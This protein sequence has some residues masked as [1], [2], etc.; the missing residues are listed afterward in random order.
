MKVDFRGKWAKGVNL[1]R[2]REALTASAL[3]GRDGVGAYLG[4][5]GLTLVQVRQGLSGVQVGH[6]ETYPVTSG[7]M[8]ELAPALKETVAAW[9]LASGP[10]S[11]AVSPHLGFCRP[12]SL[13]RAASENLAQVVAYELDRFVPVPADRLFYGFQVVEETA[14]EIRLL[15]MAVAR[16]RVEEC[17][18]L[19]TEAGLRPVA[20]ELAPVA[21]SQVFTLSGRSLPAWL[22]LHLEEDA[23]ELTLLKGGQVQAF[24]QGRHLQGRDLSR[25]VLAQVEAMAAAGMDP[26]VLGIYGRGGAAFP[27]GVLKKYE[28]ETIYA[29]QLPLPGLLPEMNLSEVLPAVGAG[30]ACFGPAAG[31]VNL[32]PPASRAAIRLG[33][34]SFTTMVLLVFLGLTCLWGASAFLHTRVELYRVNRQIAGLS[35]E[36][37]E[38]EKLLKES[39][40][41]AQQLESLGKIAESPDKLT[42]LK[43]LTRLIPANTWLVNLRL[44][45]Q[46]LD[47]SGMSTAASDLIPR[48]D[49]SGLL[50]KTEFASPIVTDADKLEHFKIKA[51]F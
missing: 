50:K 28:L 18:G 15:V 16:D 46:H 20:V 51:E 40:G 1:G 2:W 29:G 9:N 36:A 12:A 24:A 25:A 23:F 42:V 47:L 49:K 4:S 21:A 14:T 27:V 32:L 13:P 19:L 34:Y 26:R 38:V 41:L 5:D 37:N 39:R 48:L 10:V 43:E 45:K 30:L 8:A 3:M 33:R 6:W 31:G 17:L 11:L 35:P 44:S 22:L 7:P